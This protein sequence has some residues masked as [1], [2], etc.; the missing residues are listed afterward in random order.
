MTKRR[1]H[2]AVRYTYVMPYAILYLM[3]RIIATVC[4]LTA[5]FAVIAPQKAFA[6]LDPGSESYLLQF[7]LGAL[8]AGVVGIIAFWKQIKQKTHEWL[9][10]K[11]HKK[12]R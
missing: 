9:K 8:L 12:K 3:K 1:H 5:A 7:L 4:I 11:S 2:N 6:Y 10:H